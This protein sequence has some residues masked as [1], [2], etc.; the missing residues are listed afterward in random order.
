MI[1]ENKNNK[2]HIIRSYNKV[3]NN[4]EKHENDL[5]KTIILIIKRTFKGWQL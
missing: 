3:H 2:V 1:S 4:T 5:L